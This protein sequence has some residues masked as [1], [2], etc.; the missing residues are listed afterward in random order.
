MSDGGK[1]SKSRPYSVTQED[2]DKSWNAIFGPK[3]SIVGF[4]VEDG[5][6]M[7]ELTY[8]S[9]SSNTNNSK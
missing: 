3:K 8:E 5:K 1:G 9:S 2:Y 7:V 6:R 4:T